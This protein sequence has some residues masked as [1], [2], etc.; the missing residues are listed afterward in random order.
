[1]IAHTG[2]LV[3]TTCA[4]VYVYVRVRVRV[5]VRVCL[6]PNCRTNMWGW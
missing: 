3:L 1:M 5:R 2:G 4:Y 6:A